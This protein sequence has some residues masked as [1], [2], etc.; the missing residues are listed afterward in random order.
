MIILYWR[1]NA[2]T[3]ERKRPPTRLSVVRFSAGPAH[4]LLHSS[5]A[6]ARQRGRLVCVPPPPLRVPPGL[7]GVSAWRLTLYAFAIGLV[8]S[9]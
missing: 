3:L 9:T 8:L 5:Y 6:A 2:P 4:T 1:E 7:A